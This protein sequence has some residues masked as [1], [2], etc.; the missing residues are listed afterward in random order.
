MRTPLSSLLLL[1]LSTSAMA[2][3]EPSL[4]RCRAIADPAARLACYDALAAEPR[5][6]AAPVAAA[7]AAATAVAAPAAA[8]VA[9]PPAPAPKPVDNFGLPVTARSDEAQ[10]VRSAVGPSFDGWGPNTRIRLDNGQVWQITDGSSV[11][12]PEGARKVTVKRG[13]LSSFYLDFEGLKTS[14]RVRR[15]E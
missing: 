4:Q 13:A 12:L 8:A 2:Q 6:P 1:A 7:P 5:P 14:P 3:A 11:A 9:L 10:E 15:V